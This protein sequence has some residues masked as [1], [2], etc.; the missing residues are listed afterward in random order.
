MQLVNDI[1]AL[2]EQ[3]AVEFEKAT[4]TEDAEDGE[5]PLLERLLRGMS[6]AEALEAFDQLMRLPELPAQLLVARHDFEDLR[7]LAATL[8]PAMLQSEAGAGAVTMHPRPELAT[9]YVAPRNESEETVATI[10]SELLG[11]EPVGVDDDFFEL[12]GHSLAAVQIVSRIK[13]QLG[14]ELEMGDFYDTPTVA[15]MV[16]LLG[17]ESTSTPEDEITAVSREVS[18][19]EVLDDIQGLDD[20]EVEAYLAR[21]LEQDTTDVN[22]NGSEA[23]ET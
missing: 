8:S 17:E 6:A 9:P 14:L 18:E 3:V 15:H 23:D 16:E 19:D 5:S 13:Q 7:A 11:V 4:R 21:F 22:T 10:W 20:E 1:D 12:G 2:S